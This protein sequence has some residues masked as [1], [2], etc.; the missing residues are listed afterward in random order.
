MLYC[1]AKPVQNFVVATQPCEQAHFHAQPTCCKQQAMTAD[2]LPVPSGPVSSGGRDSLLCIRF[3]TVNLRWRLA[4]LC[5]Q[6]QRLLRAGVQRRDRDAPGPC[7]PML[8]VSMCTTE[9]RRCCQTL[10]LRDFKLQTCK[11]PPLLKA[12]KECSPFL[13]LACA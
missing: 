4:R 5:R 8:M 7:S 2:R 1:A 3:D 10:R 12:P 9:S 6:F 13:H 11:I